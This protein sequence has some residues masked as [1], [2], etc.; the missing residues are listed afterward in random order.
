[1]SIGDVALSAVRGTDVNG[2]LINYIVPKVE[3]GA[4]MVQQRALNGAGVF[5]I[6]FTWNTWD[7]NDLARAAGADILQIKV[8]VIPAEGD[9][10]TFEGEGYKV[11]D[12]V[13]MLEN[14]KAGRLARS[15][16][17]SKIF[18]KLRPEFQKAVTGKEFSGIPFSILSP[19][20][21]AIFA[22]LPDC[23]F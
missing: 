2:I 21:I 8:T 7:A 17:T 4:N 3:K 18:Q 10:K 22:L 11:P 1:M 6:P 15:G 16:D 9:Y 5:V 20:Q 12:A 19:D 13:Q 23:R 14:I